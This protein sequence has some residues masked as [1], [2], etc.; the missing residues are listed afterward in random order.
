M[1]LLIA[2]FVINGRAQMVNSDD[3]QLNVSFTV[4]QKKVSLT[5]LEQNKTE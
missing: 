5:A 4:S 3:N 1:M 2:L